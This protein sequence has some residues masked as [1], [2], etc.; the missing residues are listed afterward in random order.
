MIEIYLYFTK[1]NN[2]YGGTFNELLPD[3]GEVNFQHLYFDDEL[4]AEGCSNEPKLHDG[5]HVLLWHDDMN[6]QWRDDDGNPCSDEDGNPDRNILLSYLNSANRVVVFHHTGNR[7][8]IRA[9]NQLEFDADLIHEQRDGEVGF[10]H[11][12]HDTT[13]PFYRLVELWDCDTQ[14]KFHDKLEEFKED[15]FSN[16]D[17]NEENHNLEL[18]LSILHKLLGGHGNNLNETEK[19]I[20]NNN[21]HD[22]NLQNIDVFCSGSVVSTKEEI[23]K[24][25]QIRDVLLDKVNYNG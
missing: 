16:G 20:F 4:K 6:I 23:E 11:I 2:I 17:D 8:N 22:D 1:I 3:F 21:I 18:R 25:Q 14:E 15:F 10:S 19:E 24:L 9:F 7:E 12:I 13:N 5:K